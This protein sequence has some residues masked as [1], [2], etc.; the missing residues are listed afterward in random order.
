MRLLL[1]T[2]N[3]RCAVHSVVARRARRESAPT[4]PM[5]KPRTNSNH[6]GM[7]NCNDSSAGACRRHERHLRAEC[8]G[9]LSNLKSWCLYM[10]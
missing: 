6:C 9:T 2:L 5:L 7:R 8:R 4:R 3:P 10:G 1:G